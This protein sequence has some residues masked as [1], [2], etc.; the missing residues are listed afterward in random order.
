MQTMTTDAIQRMTS[1]DRI[2]VSTTPEDEAWN[3]ALAMETDGLGI[4]PEDINERTGIDLSTIT[5][6]SQVACQIEE[7]EQ[8]NYDWPLAWTD[9]KAAV[10]GGAY[11]PQA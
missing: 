4:A 3:L 2:T 10:N 8:F 9:A 11:T 6:M 5:E 1:L 7:H